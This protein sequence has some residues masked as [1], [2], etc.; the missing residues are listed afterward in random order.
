MDTHKGVQRAAEAAG[1]VRRLPERVGDAHAVRALVDA[2]ARGGALARRLSQQARRTCLRA[3]RDH[4]AAGRERRSRTRARRHAA[5]A[6]VRG[7]QHAQV[8][9]LQR[10]DER[11][12][13]D[14][15]HDRE[16]ALTRLQLT[17]VFDEHEQSRQC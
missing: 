10:Q 16:R 6:L 15:S 9:A 1:G 2:R 11:A 5:L 14:L 7:A 13:G 12:Q 8:S 17:V 4:E 3:A